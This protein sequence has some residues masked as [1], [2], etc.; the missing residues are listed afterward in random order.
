MVAKPL[1]VASQTVADF[2]KMSTLKPP[3]NL[4]DFDTNENKSDIVQSKRV[5]EPMGPPLKAQTPQINV[6]KGANNFFNNRP[7]T[8]R[9]KVE[10]QTNNMDLADLIQIKPSVIEKHEKI[11]KP[12]IPLPPVPIKV[13]PAIKVVSPPNKPCTVELKKIEKKD[14][15]TPPSTAFTK[16]RSS[17]AQIEADKKE[18][19]K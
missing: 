14:Q 5:E 10:I 8:G 15:I 3:P 1:P 6:R 17:F 19:P 18:G 7:I 2:K 12:L 16:K 13:S 11:E 4:L 9:K